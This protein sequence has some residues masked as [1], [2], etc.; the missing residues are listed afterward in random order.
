MEA[1]EQGR[2]WLWIAAVHCRLELRMGKCVQRPY[3]EDDEA[4]RP[5][6]LVLLHDVLVTLCA[7]AGIDT[8]SPEASSLA[9][10]LVGLFKSGFRS[11]QELIFM[12]SD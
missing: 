9:S 6:E 3:F 8:A 2:L 11:Q 12:A 7:K 4:I 1:G 5:E 10:T